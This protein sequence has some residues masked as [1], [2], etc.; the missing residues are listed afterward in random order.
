MRRDRENLVLFANGTLEL[1]VTAALRSYPESE[2]LEDVH[3]LMAG[4]PTKLRH[5]RDRFRWSTKG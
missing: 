3:N 4:Q 1:Y 2:S 5:V